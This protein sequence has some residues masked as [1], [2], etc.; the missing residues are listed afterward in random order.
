MICI[1]SD[2]ARLIADVDA[3]AVAG[4]NEGGD[5]VSGLAGNHD[6]AG[7][8]DRV[9]SE[10]PAAMQGPARRGWNRDS[11]LAAL[12]LMSFVIPGSLF[13][14]IVTGR[15]G[16][17]GSDNRYTLAGA[18]SVTV[19]ALASAIVA[20]LLRRRPEPAAPGRVRGGPGTARDIACALLAWLAAFWMGGRGGGPQSARPRLAV[21]LPRRRGGRH[22]GGLGGHTA[23]PP[24][25][26]IAS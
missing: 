6:P 24:A 5:N 21:P 11:T 17:F 7:R 1:T 23:V 16:Q 14:S 2:H 20:L 4:G 26:A 9:G 19:S 12:V 3:G 10:R 15:M 8:P 25:P 18:I 13:L 22:A